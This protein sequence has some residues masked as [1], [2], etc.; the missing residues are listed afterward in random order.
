[1]PQLQEDSKDFIFQQ[2]GALP[3]FHFDVRALLNANLPG[4]WIGPASHNDSP[5]F[6]WSP[7]SPDLTPCDFFLWR[8]H[9]GL[10]VHAPYAM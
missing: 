7:Q 1:M 6:T 4:H 3:H 2:D 9:Q 5:L 8:L 10:C